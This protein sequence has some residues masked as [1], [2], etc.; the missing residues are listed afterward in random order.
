MTPLTGRISIGNPS[1]LVLPKADSKPRHRSAAIILSAGAIVQIILLRD[2]LRAENAMSL[3]PAKG[4]AIHFLNSPAE[5]QWAIVVAV[6]LA[7]AVVISKTRFYRRWMFWAPER[8]P[9]R[10]HRVLYAAVAVV[11]LVEVFA[12][13]SATLAQQGWVEVSRFSNEDP[14]RQVFSADHPPAVKQNVDVDLYWALE[15]MYVWNILD[16]IPGLKVPETLTWD[17]PGHRFTN[18]FGGALLLAF[19]MLVILPVLAVLV[20]LFS[21]PGDASGAGAGGDG[22]EAHVVTNA[23][24]AAPARSGQ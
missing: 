2:L 11:V 22:A 18:G 10:W 3:H 7:A 23:A 17:D 6:T 15:R 20:A 5:R 16:A 13:V 9:N 1:R 12:S 19:K 14:P 21:K 8:D 4:G 24:S